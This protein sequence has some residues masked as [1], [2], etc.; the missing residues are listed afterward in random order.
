MADASVCSLGEAC[1][2][3]EQTRIRLPGRLLVCKR[4]KRQM[5]R[6]LIMLLSRDLGGIGDTVA[7]S[8]TK[9]GI[10]FSTNGDIG[11]ANITVR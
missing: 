6:L 1:C 5:S 7:I 4:A 10:K 2:D 9:D 3:K 11:S 8:V